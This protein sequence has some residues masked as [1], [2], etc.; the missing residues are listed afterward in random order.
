MDT[1]PLLDLWRGALHTAAAVAG[2]FVV[3]VL[4]IGLVTSLLQAATQLPDSG[5][6]FVPR[7]V[8]AGLVL[9]VAGHWLLAQLGSYTE[10]A[11]TAAAHL[12]RQVTR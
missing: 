8:A 3:A 9:A 10:A 12:A 2:P 6:A 5:L 11:F 1:G 7:L 4:V